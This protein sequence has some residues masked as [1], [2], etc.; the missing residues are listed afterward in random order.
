MTIVAVVD[1]LAPQVRYDVKLEGPFYDFE[2][3][4]DECHLA[5]CEIGVVK[6]DATGIVWRKQ[7][8][9]IGDWSLINGELKLTFFDDGTQLTLSP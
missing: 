2:G 4:F 7:M 8:P 1:I 9:L 5:I 6:F 3:P